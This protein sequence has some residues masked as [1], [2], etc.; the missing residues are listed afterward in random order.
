MNWGIL[1]A[2]GIATLPFFMLPSIL[3]FKNRKRLAALILVLNLLVTAVLPFGA[4][5]LLAVVFGFESPYIGALPLIV[6]IAAWLALLGFGIRSDA[7]T[8]LDIDE[9]VKL[10]EYDATWPGAFAEE[11]RRIVDAV[12]ISAERIEHIGSTAVPG[13]PAKPVV[14]MMLGVD[15]LPPSPD[16]L[17]RLQILGYQNLGEAGVPG[18]VYL[19]LRG[20]LQD[21][22][23]HVMQRGGEL[24]RGN[25]AF[26]ELLC[27]DPEARERY[28]R[29]KAGAMHSG[30]GRLLAYSDA[31]NP[32]VAELMA[33]AR[34]R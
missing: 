2:I 24:W 31:K 27:R 7:A 26:R 19:R 9:P 28:S 22:N 30:G 4:G 25:L 11:R 16:L 12:A 6:V 34:A 1:L 13:M 21:F 10:V 3:A 29:G 8:A 17:S 14:D 33:A 23:L 20:G 32:L 15:R 5:A 18:R